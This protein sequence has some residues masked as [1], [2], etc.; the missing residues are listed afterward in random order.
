MLRAGGLLLAVAVCLLLSCDCF[1]LSRQHS[2]CRND[3]MLR[4]LFARLIVTGMTAL[5]FVLMLGAH[6]LAYAFARK[7]TTVVTAALKGLLF[8]CLCAHSVAMLALGGLTLAGALS[9]PFC[10]LQPP[11]SSPPPLDAASLLLLLLELLVPSLLCGSDLCIM[12]FS[13]HA[14]YLLWAQTKAAQASS[15]SDTPI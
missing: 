14:V 11:S 4:F 5:L 15:A 10:T 7:Q 3:M 8:V 12:V 6:M 13:G 9:F 2:E 1:R